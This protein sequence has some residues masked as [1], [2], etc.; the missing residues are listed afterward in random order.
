M[1]ACVFVFNGIGFL[2]VLIPPVF[3][4]TQPSAARYEV[5]GSSGALYSSFRKADTVGMRPERASNRGVQFD[6]E[7]NN[8][9]GEKGEI[10]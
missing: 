3:E 9:G 1:P 4:E 7:E 2:P 10:K 5:K 8:E 6:G